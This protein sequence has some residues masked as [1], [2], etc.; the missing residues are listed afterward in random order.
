MLFLCFIGKVDMLSF[1]KILT[2]MELEMKISSAVVPKM[3]YGKRF[4]LDS[5][6]ILTKC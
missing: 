5:M 4:K 6:E 1:R 2:K 3:E